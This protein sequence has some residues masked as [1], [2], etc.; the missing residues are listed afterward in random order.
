MV[1]FVISCMCAK[2]FA[3]Q[4]LS[5]AFEFGK[6]HSEA[7]QLLLQRHSKIRETFSG[8]FVYSSYFRM[9]LQWHLSGFGSRSNTIAAPFGRVCDHRSD[10][11]P[12]QRHSEGAELNFSNFPMAL[13]GLFCKNLRTCAFV[14]NIHFSR[15]SNFS[16]SFY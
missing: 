14:N 6:I 8:D 2:I 5:F 9:A 15:S 3:P 7:G 13:R 12:L 16:R 4:R 1:H 11:I 10:K